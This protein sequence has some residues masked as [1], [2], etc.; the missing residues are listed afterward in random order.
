MSCLARRGERVKFFAQKVGS[1]PRLFETG[2]SPF[3]Y[4]FSKKILKLCV[5]CSLNKFFCWVTLGRIKCLMMEDMGQHKTWVIVHRGKTFYIP[6]LFTFPHAGFLCKTT[7][8]LT[9]RDFYISK[10]VCNQM[11]WVSSIKLQSLLEKSLFV[12][13]FDGN[14]NTLL[15]IWLLFPLSALFHSK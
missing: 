13:F 7:S 4:F 11:T 2:L 12:F 15:T 6:L 1:T 9:S 10:N 5:L 3:W 8:W 14:V